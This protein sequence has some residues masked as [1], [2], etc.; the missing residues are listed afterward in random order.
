MRCSRRSSR[1][2]ASRGARANRRGTIQ[3]ALNPNKQVVDLILVLE[4]NAPDFVT[5]QLNLTNVCGHYLNFSSYTV[6][7][8][9]FISSM[10]ILLLCRRGQF[11]E[12]SSF[13]SLVF[14]PF[15]HHTKGNSKTEY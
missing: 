14:A 4:L 1:T 12:F 3:K 13:L 5:V 8:P 6:S 10:T 9:T 15:D 7:R 11:W 2:S